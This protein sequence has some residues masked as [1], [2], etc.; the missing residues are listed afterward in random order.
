VFRDRQANAFKKKHED[1]LLRKALEVC[2]SFE[3]DS[4]V[5]VL[6]RFARCAPSVFKQAAL[7]AATHETVDSRQQHLQCAHNACN[8]DDDDVVVASTAAVDTTCDAPTLA[9][10]V[11]HLRDEHHYCLYCAC[12]YAS[13]EE[14][15]SRCPG[16]TEDD[17]E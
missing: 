15:S 1:T 12:R 13:F 3:T 7:Q 10:T 14:M 8:T 9:E 6:S 11:D 4:G 17:H 16:L 2:A 5:T